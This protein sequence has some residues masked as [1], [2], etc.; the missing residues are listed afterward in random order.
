MGTPFQGSSLYSFIQ[1]K[2][3]MVIKKIFNLK[4]IYKTI[5]IL[6]KNIGYNGII[7]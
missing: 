3:I 7:V 1:Y 5:K 2:I 4:K 6:K